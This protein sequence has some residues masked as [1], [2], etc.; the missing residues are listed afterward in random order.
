MSPAQKAI[1]ENLILGFEKPDF[2]MGEGD[3]PVSV[4]V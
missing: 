3:T 2:K 4:W 1:G